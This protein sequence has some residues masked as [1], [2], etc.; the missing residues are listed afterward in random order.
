MSSYLDLRA[1]KY[2][3]PKKTASIDFGI[4]HTQSSSSSIPNNKKRKPEPESPILKSRKRQKITSGT[5]QV[6]ST[7]QHH[8]PTPVNPNAFRFDSPQIRNSLSK[9]RLTQSTVPLSNTK[10]QAI[11]RANKTI[12]NLLDAEYKEIFSNINEKWNRSLTKISHEINLYGIPSNLQLIEFPNSPLNIGVCAKVFIPCGSLLGL[13]TG[14]YIVEPYDQEWDGSDT[15]YEFQIADEIW[16]TQSEKKRLCDAGLL[17]TEN[18]E[19]IDRVRIT[20]ESSKEGC[21]TRFINHSLKHYNTIARPAKLNGRYVIA[22]VASENIP[23][24]HQLLF[25]YTDSYWEYSN[26]QPLETKPDG[27]LC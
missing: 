3:Q 10:Q 23:K 15:S 24:K 1:L 6:F 27:H 17:Q 16:A 20:I 13:Y 25:N 21:F 18:I 7:F 14:R 22:I 9:Y 4:P 11:V 19:K 5:I 26:I 2:V 12:Q 8:R